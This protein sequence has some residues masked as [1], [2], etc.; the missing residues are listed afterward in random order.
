[1]ER[2]VFIYFE[3][4]F[5]FTA[6]QQLPRVPCKPNDALTIGDNRCEMLSDSNVFPM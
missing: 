4:T 6:N 2:L 1:M 5:F 3:T